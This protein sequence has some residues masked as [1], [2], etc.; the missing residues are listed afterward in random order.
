MQMLDGLSY[1]VN[2]YDKEA[3]AMCSLCYFAAAT[4]EVLF[5]TGKL[6]KH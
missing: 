4:H 5:G 1:I 3:K 2:V 6:G